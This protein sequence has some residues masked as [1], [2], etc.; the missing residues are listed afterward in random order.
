MEVPTAK[1][2]P[3]FGKATRHVRVRSKGVRQRTVTPGCTD[4]EVRPHL[5]PYA[6]STCS[7]E[8]SFEFEVH[9][10]GCAACFRDLRSLGRMS[11]L[12]R[13]LLPDSRAQKNGTH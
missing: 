11:R 4:P 9:L 5:L 13:E 3:R 8:E 6:L 7:E 12:L 10:L 1:L 2:A